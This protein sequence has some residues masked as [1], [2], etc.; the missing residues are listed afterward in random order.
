MGRFLV[1]DSSDV[2]SEC[3]RVNDVQLLSALGP[4]SALARR[5]SSL[6]GE[7]LDREAI[8]KWKERGRIAHA[9]RPWVLLVATQD[10]VAV[11]RDIALPS[12]AR[13]QSAA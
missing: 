5:L 7:P 3:G 9:W 12:P 8:Y 1:V 11:S 2:S 10:G 4:A 6:A 13:G